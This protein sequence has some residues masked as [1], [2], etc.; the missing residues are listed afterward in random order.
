MHEIN[1]QNVS[2]ELVV[3]EVQYE[4]LDV[5]DDKYYKGNSILYFLG[6]FRVSA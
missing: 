5:E 4:L 3:Q 6:I 2:H 1:Q